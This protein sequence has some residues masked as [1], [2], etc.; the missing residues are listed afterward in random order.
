MKFSQLYSL[1]NNVNIFTAFHDD[2]ILWRHDGFFNFLRIMS[3]L[4]RYS[5]WNICLV[6]K[7]GK[8][9]NLHCLTFQ[10]Q[11]TEHKYHYYSSTICILNI[12]R[13]LSRKCQKLGVSDDVIRKIVTSAKIFLNRNVS[14]I[15]NWQCTKF[16][17]SRTSVA[18]MPE[19]DSA[20]PE[21]TLPKKPGWNRVKKFM[22]IFSKANSSPSLLV[23]V[24]GR[25]T[26]KHW[27]LSSSSASW[28]ASANLKIF[29]II[30]LIKLKLLTRQNMHLGLYYWHT[31]GVCPLQ[32]SIWVYIIDRP[33]MYTL[34]RYLFG[35]ILLTYPQCMP[36]A[37]MHL[38]EPTD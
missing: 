27:D 18:E 21:I 20:P 30:K 23:S 32:V 15:I 26:T 13:F 1:P 35:L 12:T 5:G 19:G 3:N 24:S 31:H 25:K 28:L 33:T 11:Q 7:T 9:V 34:R 17:Y 29:C 37:V 10:N 22:N 38:G 16:H 36:S 6:I 2:V 8:Y 4:A 14:Y